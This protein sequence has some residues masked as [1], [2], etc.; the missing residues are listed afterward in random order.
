MNP[1]TIAA[2]SWLARAS[3]LILFASLALGLILPKLAGAG[4]LLLGLMAFIWLSATRRW[5]LRGLHASERLLTLA[6]LIYVTATLASLAWHAFDPA[7]TQSAG[8]IARLLLILPLFLYL[9]QIDRLAPYWWHGLAAGGLIAG[10][11]AW[12]FLLT[13]QI[14]EFEQRVGGATNPIY[15]GGIALLLAFMLL[16]RL[17][18]ANLPVWMRGLAALGVLGGISASLLSGSRGAWIAALP[19]L[20]LF[21]LG[22][23]QRL[24]PSSRYGLP[25]LI[26]L[27]V[28]ALNLL[29]NVNM[30]Q[31]MLDVGREISAA[32]S[33]EAIE[34]GV[35]ERLQ[36]WAIALKLII[37]EPWLGPGNA[38]FTAAIADAVAGGQAHPQLLEYRHPHNQFLSALLYAGLPGLLG[39]ILLFF[40]PLRRFW[41]IRRSSLVSTQQLAWCGLAALAMLAAMALTESIF[42]RNI[43]VV[44]FGL[45][46]ATCLGLLGSERRR[47]LAAAKDPRRHSLGAILIV[48]NEADRIRACLGALKGWADEIIVLDSGSTD[49]TVAICREYTDQVHE[50]DWPGFGPQKQRALGHAKSDW[51]LSLDADEVL[52]PELKTEIDFTLAQDPPP[53]QAYT[54]PWLTHAFGTTLQHGHWARAPLRLF[55][56]G[57]G[58]FTGAAVHEKV[59][60]A[61]G[62]RIG[63]LQAPLHHYSYRDVDHAR[64][65]LYDYASLQA[66]ERH[67]AG[68]RLR[69][70]ITAWLRATLNWLDNFL[71]RAAFLDG[72]GG[73]IMSRLNAAYTREK[74]LTLARLSADSR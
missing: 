27:G 72:R 24:H 46:L 15:F 51:I 74:Y 8:R 35:S 50:T 36:M 61:P 49:E 39:L 21:L 6:V 60:M 9:R 73:W 64:A 11:Y 47:E 54:L 19:L 66:E 42:E 62:C 55:Q 30:D 71:L 32:L 2:D 52:D 5:H 41:L 1:S 37:E 40:L 63:H 43:G 20:V 33:G 57:Q 58:R 28:A 25:L 69:W 14:G 59:V 10:V 68:R 7:G 4:F 3:G 13:G 26:V 70:P 17:G 67:A 23:T 45:I 12:W 38:A 34:G 48:C 22:F 31:R 18:E 65:K 53:H 44:W 56:R 29:P 16:P